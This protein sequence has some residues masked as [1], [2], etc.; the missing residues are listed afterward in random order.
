MTAIK[1]FFVPFIVLLATIGCGGSQS[2][3]THPVVNMAVFDLSCP[4][5]KLTFIWP[6]CPREGTAVK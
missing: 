6:I 4:K 2:K 1:Y 3:Q 5:K